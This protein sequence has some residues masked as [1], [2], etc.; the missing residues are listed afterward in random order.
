MNKLSTY[1][2]RAAYV[3]AILEMDDAKITSQIYE[4]IRVIERRRLDVLQIDDDENR[5]L[6]AADMEIQ[7]LI[8]ERIGNTD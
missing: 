6:A 3:S 8:T 4:V 2:W 7:A 1:L 5:A